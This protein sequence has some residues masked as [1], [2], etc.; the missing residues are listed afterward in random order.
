MPRNIGSYIN[1]HIRRTIGFA[2]SA[3]DVTYD[4]KKMIQILRHEF[5]RK[6][7]KLFEGHNSRH[8]EEVSDILEE[9]NEILCEAQADR[10][11]QNKAKTRMDKHLNDVFNSLERLR[12]DDQKGLSNQKTI[13]K[14]SRWKMLVN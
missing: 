8:D 5:S 10:L 3:P 9:Y 4:T 12:D 13:T 7:E 14:S 2:L 11:A 6:R 1:S